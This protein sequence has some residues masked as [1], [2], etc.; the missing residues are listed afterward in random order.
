MLDE[1]HV[2]LVGYHM[3]ESLFHIS[4]RSAIL[5]EA[6]KSGIVF[7]VNELGGSL[8]VLLARLSFFLS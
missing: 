3:T 6:E 2:V 1:P 7:D 5:I 8:E 4:F